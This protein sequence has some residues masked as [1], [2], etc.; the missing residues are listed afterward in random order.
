MKRHIYGTYPEEDFDKDEY[1]VH[2]LSV[3]DR[4]CEV[5]SYCICG[6]DCNNNPIHYSTDAE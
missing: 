5:C 6:R 3:E 2:N 1:C 4:I